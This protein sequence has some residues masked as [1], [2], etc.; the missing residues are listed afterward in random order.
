VAVPGGLDS[1]LASSLLETPSLPAEIT[2]VVAGASTSALLAYPVQF[3]CNLPDA[4][5]QLAGAELYIRDNAIILVPTFE[6]LDG[7][8]LARSR[9]S[10][11]SVTIP[12][13]TIRPGSY[14]VTITGERTS[15]SWPL[16]VH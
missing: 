8:L 16:Q 6:E 13:G 4:K 15:R 2:H 9:E 14:R 5:R 1:D 10:V 11:V 3:T 7:A 12:P